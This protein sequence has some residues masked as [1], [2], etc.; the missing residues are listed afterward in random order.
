MAETVSPPS[1]ARRV[2]RTKKI[3]GATRRRAVKRASKAIPTTDEQAV[4]AAFD[5]AHH[6][7]PVATPIDDSAAIRSRRTLI[8][9]V[10]GVMLI[11][12]AGWV[13]SLRYSL[14]L[15]DPTADQQAQAAQWQAL[16][17]E[18]ETSFTSITDSLAAVREQQTEVAQTAVMLDAQAVGEVEKQ[19]IADQVADWVSYRNF[20]NGLTVKY[21]PTW[22]RATGDDSATIVFR[23]E[24]QTI[25]ITTTATATRPA[26]PA[27]QTEVFFIGTVP[28]TLYRENTSS[29]SRLTVVA[30][31]SAIPT[32]VVAEGTGTPL[33]E[34]TFT[35]L[36][37]TISIT[38]AAPAAN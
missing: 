33:D 34:A 21:P 35:L 30:P 15:P 29:G 37:K 13:W 11:I 2:R 17:Q 7:S 24:S 8:I 36:V 22:Q 4:K 26:V 12:V 20:D 23:H 1:A 32:E 3:P 31:F 27:E 9:A 6:H 25:R 28:G 14:R 18:L 38:P 5:V 16:R 19:L 10:I